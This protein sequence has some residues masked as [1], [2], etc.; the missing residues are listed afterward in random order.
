MVGED[1]ESGVN[2]GADFWTRI[3]KPYILNK[4]P[5]FVK[6]C[7]KA[8]LYI[9]FFGQYIII[10]TVYHLLPAEA[11]APIQHNTFPSTL[12]QY[13]HCTLYK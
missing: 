12:P 13:I 4:L 3:W 11:L 7:P 6:S 2:S 1:G 9:I 8:I 10:H 5:S